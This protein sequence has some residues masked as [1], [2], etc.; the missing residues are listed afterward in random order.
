MPGVTGR[1]M[2]G[3]AFAKHGTNSWGVA[4][5]VTKGTYFF[6]DG[7]VKYSP[8]FNEDRSFGQSFLGPAEAGD[9]NPSDLTLTGHARYE[10]NN[11]ILRALAM[12]SPAAVTL[13][14]SAAG[15]TPSFSHVIDLAPS[16]DGLGATFAMDRKLFVEEIPSARVYGFSERPGDGG[17]IE[18]SF[19]VLG[20]APTNLSTTNTNS[21]VYGAS[22]PSLLGRVFRKQ[23][24]FRINAQDGGALGGSDT[25]SIL[26]SLE[27]T[28]ERPQDRSYAYGSADIIEAGDNDFPVL[29][30]RLIFARANTLTVNSFRAALQVGTAYKADVTYLGTF[31]NSTDRRSRLY[32]FPYLEIQ[33]ESTPTQGAAQIKPDCMFMLKLP[34]SAPT[35]MTGVV[36]P[37]RLTQIMTNSVVAF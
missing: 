30:A 6:S 10:D 12:G 3:W 24:T 4:V 34:A 20:V 1:D 15:Q 5:S 31:I 14:N 37:F 18:E 28:F 26:G 13:S 23:G 29:S 2:K 21:T 8:Q 16:I 32:Q 11:Y 33:D 19:R 22:F 27:F 25:I 9:L 36:M 35:G 17:I 7:G